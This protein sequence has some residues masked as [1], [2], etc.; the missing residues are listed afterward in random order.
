MGAVRAEDDEDDGMEG[1]VGVVVV[2][3]VACHLR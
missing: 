2:F 3:V 1:G